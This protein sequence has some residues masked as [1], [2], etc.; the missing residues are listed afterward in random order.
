M[1]HNLQILEKVIFFE[2]LQVILLSFLEIFI[3]TKVTKNA[4][5]LSVQVWRSLCIM[6][7]TLKTIAAFWTKIFS[8]ALTK[9]KENE[10]S[11]RKFIFVHTS[12]IAYS[13][14]ITGFTHLEKNCDECSEFVEQSEGHFANHSPS[15]D[16]RHDCTAHL[17]VFLRG[18]VAQSNAMDRGL[19]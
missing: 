14:L 8:L 13:R 10:A 3:I 9:A 19:G 7:V 16:A 4:P 6:F 17:V 2:D 15:F 12:S 18:R 1:S 5:S 11:D